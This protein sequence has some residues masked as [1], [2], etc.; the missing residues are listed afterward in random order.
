[1]AVGQGRWLEITRRTWEAMTENGATTRAGAAAYYALTAL[2][3]FLA[4]VVTL[5]AQLAPDLTGASGRDREQAEFLELLQRNLPSEASD[6]VA[7]QIGRIQD[8]PAVGLLSI[9]IVV[10]LWLASGLVGT[11]IDALNRIHGVKETRSY[12]S[13]T[14]TAV[15]LTA[16]EAFIAIGVLGILV[17][18]PVAR[19]DGGSSLAGGLLRVSVEWVVVGAAALVSFALIRYLGPNC[20]SRWRWLTPGSLL[21]TAAFLASGLVLRLY[22][23]RLGDYAGTYGS[24]AGVMLLLLWFWLAAIILLAVAQLDQVLED[25]RENPR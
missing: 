9:G 16:V 14:F 6:L 2:V 4:V 19:G 5:G 10:S 18:G 3:P 23:A 11:I 21:G 15:A 25:E 1:M 20:R 17:V 8:R 13:L 12:L 24:L 22:S 7:D